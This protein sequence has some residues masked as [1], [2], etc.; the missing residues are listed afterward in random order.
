MVWVT[1]ISCNEEFLKR[2]RTARLTT[3]T[4]TVGQGNAPIRNA[5]YTEL[6]VMI[7]RPII[8]TISPWW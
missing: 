5:T 6:V 4:N 7:N 8:P 1:F 3:V 2:L